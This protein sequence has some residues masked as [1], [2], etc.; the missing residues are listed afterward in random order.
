[1]KILG[2]TFPSKFLRSVCKASRKISGHLNLGKGKN[3][4][5]ML[6]PALEKEAITFSN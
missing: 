5:Q 2:N 6:H 3:S 1:M 4:G